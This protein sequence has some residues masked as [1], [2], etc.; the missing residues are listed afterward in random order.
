MLF[1]C[2]IRVVDS[3]GITQVLLRFAFGFVCEWLEMLILIYP[4]QKLIDLFLKRR[5]TIFE[6]RG[7]LL[8]FGNVLEGL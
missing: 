7:L 6:S 8:A 4:S 3:M 1:L 5:K 2:F